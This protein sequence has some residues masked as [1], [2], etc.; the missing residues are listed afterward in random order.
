MGALDSVCEAGAVRHSCPEPIKREPQRSSWYRVKRAVRDLNLGYAEE[1][2]ITLKDLPG[3]VIESIIML[4][5]QGFLRS[6][7]VF[8]NDTVKLGY[9]LRFTQNGWVALPLDAGIRFT[10]TLVWTAIAGLGAGFMGSRLI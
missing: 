9:K 5:P 2:E 10:E 8:D 3:H 4:P 7:E 6:G 1:F